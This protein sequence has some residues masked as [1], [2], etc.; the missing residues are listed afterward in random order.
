[1]HFLSTLAV[2]ITVVLLFF[3][4]NLTGKNDITTPPDAL[5]TA[6]IA[7]TETPTT[8]EPESNE[9]QTA[10]P[11]PTDEI[12]P[13]MQPADPSP[14]NVVERVV[15]EAEARE[16]VQAL[17]TGMFNSIITNT[18][19]T[20]PDFVEDNADTHLALRWVDY[21]GNK[22]AETKLS[23]FSPNGGVTVDEKPTSYAEADLTVYEVKCN[24]VIDTESG[25][26]Y[27]QELTYKLS[28]SVNEAGQRSVKKLELIDDADYNE[29]QN[30]LEANADVAAIDAYV[31]G[32]LG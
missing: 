26:P 6:E 22:L 21:K 28:Y 17:V 20:A 10:A 15:S 7:G 23:S 1:M 13:T 9:D 3:G 27:E 5:P 8:P 19:Y 16:D 32:L 2:I 4:V 29:L 18:P 25:T 14:T 11:T 31:D 30:N 12:V 24:V